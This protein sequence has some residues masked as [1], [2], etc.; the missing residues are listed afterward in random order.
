MKKFILLFGILFIPKFVNASDIYV[1]IGNTFKAD[2][3]SNNTFSISLKSQG[4]TY[5]A[6]YFKKYERTPW[7]EWLNRYPQW[8]VVTI[9]EHIVFSVTRTLFNYKIIKDFNLFYDLGLSYTTNLS[10]AT[11]SH[12][13][14]KQ[15]L[16]I[17]YKRV[18]L[19][20]AHDSNAGLVPP[21]TGEDV[22]T[23]DFELY[24]F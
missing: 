15:R 24:R 19:Y 13:L 6:D 23:F 20:Y 10:R 2:H 1:G 17:E 14:V 3:P 8:G 9:K 16:G 11:S 12:F 7:V 18:R 4:W 21:N 5:S 22:I